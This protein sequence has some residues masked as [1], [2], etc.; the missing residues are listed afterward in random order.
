MVWIGLELP[1]ADKLASY[2]NN[3]SERHS[4]DRFKI[5]DVLLK[6]KLVKAKLLSDQGHFSIHALVN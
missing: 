6:T 4:T 3:D 2:H 1:T 5:C